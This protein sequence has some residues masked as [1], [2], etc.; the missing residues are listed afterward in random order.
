MYKKR[1]LS[2]KEGRMGVAT[3]TLIGEVVF[4]TDIVREYISAGHASSRS[5]MRFL[6]R[7]FEN[8]CLSEYRLLSAMC[9]RARGQSLDLTFVEV[10]LEE[11]YLT[12]G[13][14]QALQA[15]TDNTEL[16]ASEL[17]EKLCAEISGRLKQA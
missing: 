15:I 7:G 17:V 11:V 16:S 6:K 14:L 2:L 13:V 10:E 9:A 4:P 12:T 3:G 1:L 5:L 8:A